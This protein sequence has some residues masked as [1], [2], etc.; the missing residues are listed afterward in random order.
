MLPTDPKRPKIR[1]GGLEAAY[2]KSIESQLLSA[3]AS[4]AAIAVA[5]ATEGTHEPTVQSGTPKER[6][7]HG[8]IRRVVRLPGRALPFI[9]TIDLTL[10]SES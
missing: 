8:T 7:K 4:A 6:T 2:R 1:R 5:A 9:I 3:V 10:Y